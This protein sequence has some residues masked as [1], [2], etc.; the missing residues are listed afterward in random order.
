M[1]IFRLLPAL[2]LFAATAFGQTLTI[3]QTFGG[4][5]N[6]SD[7][8]VNTTQ[9]DVSLAP[10][11]ANGTIS[12]VHVYWS[13][14]GCTNAVKIK[15]FHRAGNTFT[16]YDE[17]GPFT[18]SG[19]DSLLLMFPS[20]TVQQGDLI[21]VARVANCGNAGVLFGIVG[22]GYLVFTGDVSGS[23]DKSS[24]ALSQGTPLFLYGTGTATSSIANVMVVVGSVAG[25][26]GSQFKTDLQM[27]N[28]GSSTLTGKVIFHPA[29][30]SGT[31]S[32]PS[33]DYSVAPGHVGGVPDIGSL[34]FT[35]LGS[36]DFLV[37]AGQ[38]APPWRA[39]STT[40]AR[41]ARA[42]SAKRWSRRAAAIRI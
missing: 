24:A 34:G 23:F 15:F 1:R 30:T 10:A 26:F 11:T 37:P 38:T 12:Q 40:Q 5:P 28:T 18:P 21:G 20:V 36:I 25:S 7:G 4:P 3:G 22:T 6:A 32:D 8:F 33:V 13:S 39:S 19:G 2:L 17:R 16:M 9:T 31:Q 35:G 27:L 14:S 29:G 41:T 42:V